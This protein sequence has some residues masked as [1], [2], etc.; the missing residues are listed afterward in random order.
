MNKR[1]QTLEEKILEFR[2]KANPVEATFA[3]VHRYDGQFG[4]YSPVFRKG[5]HQK[6]KQYARNLKKFY[7]KKEKLSGEEL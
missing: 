3:G 5:Y 1:F 2:W 6:L 7:N 4:R